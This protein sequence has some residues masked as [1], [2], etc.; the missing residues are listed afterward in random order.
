[1]TDEQLKDLTRKPNKTEAEWRTL[2]VAGWA[3]YDDGTDSYR[4]S[5]VGLAGGYDA[6]V[7]EIGSLR[8]QGLGPL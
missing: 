3:D 7:K 2:W 8:A 1:M 4:L 5:L 6:Y